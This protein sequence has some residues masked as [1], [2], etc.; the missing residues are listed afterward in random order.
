LTY[1]NPRQ[2]EWPAA[3]FIVGNPP[4]IGKGEPMRTAFGE[5]YLDGLR[6]AHPDME[7]SADFVLYWWD[8]AA[9]LLTS[10][11]TVLRRFGFVTTNSITQVFNRRVVERHLNATTPISLVFAIPD[12]PWT[13]ATSDAAAVRIAMTVGEAGRR[14][15]TLSK[16]IREAR[17]DSDEPVVVLE[18]TEG[19]IN[20]DLTVGVDVTSAAVLRAN[21]G[22][23][24]MGPALGGRGFVLLPV[25]A[26]QLNPGKSGTW[27]KKL[28]TGK[29]ITGRHRGRFVIDV[30]DYESEAALRKELPQVYQR[31]K[32]TVYPTRKTNND[33]KLREF[34]WKFRRSNEV[35]FNA[36]EGLKRFIA[37]VETTKH[38]TFVF[39]GSDELLEHGV[40]GFG[41]DDA[42][43]LGVLSS[44][45][46]IS[47]AL[48]NGG[49]LE[50]RP[51]YNKDV[52][53]DTFPFP[54]ATPAQQT[55]IRSIAEEL[56]AHRKRVLD[57]H[58]ELTLTGLYNV[59]DTLRAGADPSAL[60]AGDR[61]VFDDGLVLV[62]RELHDRLDAA[63]ANAYG[64]PADL[65]ND[66][67]VAR[68]VALNGQRIAEEAK[69]VVHW[70]RSTYQIPR[71]GSATDKPKFELIGGGAAT[72]QAPAAKPLFP[73]DDLEQTAAVLATLARSAVALNVTALARTFK[74]GRKCELKVRSVLA[75][76]VRMGYVMTTD[77]GQTYLLRRVA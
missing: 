28:T 47:W 61:H 46:H 30:R 68:L 32:E 33:P 67:I 37:T 3:E 5:A 36:T 4:F 71:F 10:K 15:G 58:S 41:F 18:P 74:Q 8:R 9:D 24:S 39:V 66:E 63:V 42:W 17:L 1:K 52:C 22:L 34:W 69:G 35:Y 16:V 40:I 19:D 20:S 48:A 2:P 26:R 56:D 55:A 73:G 6:E 44:R 65:T 49:T 76:L 25:Q 54:A 21:D 51:R 60:D 14:T 62:L 23:A 38:R 53:F 72:E 31:L 59:L 13:K 11:N 45:Q 27:L 7:E 50:D 29:D 75:A 70:L 57:Q 77:S 64:W 12:H 43:V